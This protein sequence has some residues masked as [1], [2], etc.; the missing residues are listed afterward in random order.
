MR[1]PQQ[2]HRSDIRPNTFMAPRGGAALAP[3]RA[4]DFRRKR[5]EYTG[6]A[7]WNLP[8]PAPAAI[9]RRLP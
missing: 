5:S 4:N 3:S 2:R 9:A 7:G 6:P 8:A 1:Y